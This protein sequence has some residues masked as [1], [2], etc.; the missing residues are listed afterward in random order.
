MEVSIIIPVYNGEKYIK[1][2]LDS[3]LK[4]TYE[5]AEVIIIN[6]GSIDKTGS[7]CDDYSKKNPQ[8]SV[9][10][11]LKE[12]LICARKAGIELAKGRY[13]AWVDADDWIEPDFIETLYTE[14]QKTNADIIISG[15]IKEKETASIEIKN[16]FAPGVYEGEQLNNIIGKM[17]FYSDF[18]EFGIQPY[19]WNKLYKKERLAEC[20]KNLDTN[21]YDGEDAAVI[22]PYILNSQKIC[23]LDKSLYHYN[24]HHESMTAEKKEDF[25]ENVSRLYL[26]L[27]REFVS[28]AYK[29]TLLPQLDQYMR[30]MVWQKDRMAFLKS[31]K[32]FFP[33]KQVPVGSQ[34]IIYGAGEVGRT[35]H[36][37]ILQSQFANI[38]AWVDRKFETKEMRNMGIESPLIIMERKYDHIVIAMENEKAKE[39]IK[40]KLLDI[41]VS[42]KKII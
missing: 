24:I 28:S 3:V 32:H 38:V 11:K 15:C 2:C 17:L 20:Y 39:S 5:G 25:Y 6:D 31:Q 10:H 8:I 23:L 14:M 22:F 42:I 21:I 18:F 36:Y 34:I 7:I 37:Q 26:Q 35:Y 40:K 13:I 27:Y 16:K 29:E 4:Q 9:Y 19:I 41:G 1:R 30:M 12:G 33:F